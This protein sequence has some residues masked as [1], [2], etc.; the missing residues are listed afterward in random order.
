VTVGESNYR[1]RFGHAWTADA[2]SDARGD[3]VETALW[4]ALRSLQEKARWSRRMSESFG[5]GVISKR[6]V[7]LAE[8][9]EL[10][11]TVL[12]RRLAD[13]GHGRQERDVV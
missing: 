8:E 4:I 2:L 11:M 9:A 1:C 10:A 3:E 6:Y 13:S 5:P 12:R 7:E